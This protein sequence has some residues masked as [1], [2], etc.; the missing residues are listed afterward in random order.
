M[1]YVNILQDVRYTGLCMHINAAVCSNAQVIT[2]DQLQKPSVAAKL[3]N[4]FSLTAARPP[5]SEPRLTRPASVPAARPRGASSSCLEPVGLALTKTDELVV[6]N[7]GDDCSVLMY[8]VEGR[9]TRRIDQ[10]H[11][12]HPAAKCRDDAYDCKDDTTA[13]EPDIK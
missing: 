7:A 5:S 10:R 9:L 11:L 6:A 13:A 12:L 2:A 8:D 3:I 4:K 1:R